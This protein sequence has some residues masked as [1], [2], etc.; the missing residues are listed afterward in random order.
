MLAHVSAL[1]M[2]HALKVTQAG[3][4]RARKFVAMWLV[5]VVGDIVQHVFKVRIRIVAWVA[6]AAAMTCRP[7]TKPRTT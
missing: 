1:L 7:G 5:I 4:V 2:K 3:G 6:V